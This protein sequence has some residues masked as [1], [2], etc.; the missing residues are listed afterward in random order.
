MGKWWYVYWLW[1]CF[2]WCIHVPKLIE[3]YTLN[4]QRFLKLLKVMSIFLSSVPT[5]IKQILFI[6]SCDLPYSMRCLVLWYIQICQSHCQ[7]LKNI[8]LQCLNC[9]ESS[10][11]Y[12]YTLRRHKLFFHS[13][14]TSVIAQITESKIKSSFCK[15]MLTLA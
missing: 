15:E 11:P 3:L 7:Y 8:L 12:P 1:W 5:E 9:K 4:V 6:R 2:H 13:D 14:V 10:L